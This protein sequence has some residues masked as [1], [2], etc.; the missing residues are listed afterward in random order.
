MSENENIHRGH[1]IRLR[2]RF[3]TE[4]LKSFEPHEVLELLLFYAIPKRDTNATAHLLLQ[5]F[6]RLDKVFDASIDE[7][8]S[9]EG[10]GYNTAVLLKL[11]PEIA[12]YYAQERFQDTIHIENSN[13]MG[14]YMCSRI[15]F[16]PKEV[17]AAAVLD[18]RRREIAFK[19]M[20]E[21]IVSQTAVN[22]RA[23]AEFAIAHQAETMVIAHNHVS[24]DPVPS[25]SD[26]DT[27]RMICKALFGI[28]VI[29]SDHIIV[30]GEKYYSFAENGI[31]PN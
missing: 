9:V 5:K 26:R 13:E 3:D 10:I 16:L 23:L 20:D 22:I 8:I 6:G 7:L 30:A 18:S 4:G 15:G 21:G 1:R 11:I 31:L 25:Q 29:V 17:L 24:G 14:K 2:R 27:T 12:Q 28:G 19:I